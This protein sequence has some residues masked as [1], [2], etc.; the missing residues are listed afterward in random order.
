MP[1]YSMV[2]ECTDRYEVKELPD[3]AAEIAIRV[4]ARFRDLWLVKLSALETTAAEIRQY[5]PEAH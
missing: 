1:G 4:P 2:Q 5:Q 3:G